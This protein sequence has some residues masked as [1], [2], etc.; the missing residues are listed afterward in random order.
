VYQTRLAVVYAVPTPSFAP[1]VQCGGIRG[2][3][4]AIDFGIPRY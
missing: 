2:P 4:G 1:R 3:P